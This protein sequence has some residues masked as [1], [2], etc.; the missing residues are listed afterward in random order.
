MYTQT[1][2]EILE[3]V[4]E[5]ISSLLILNYEADA[6]NLSLPDLTDSAAVVET[7]AQ[8][9]VN[10]GRSLLDSGDDELRTNMPP[11]CETG[12]FFGPFQ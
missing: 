4:A 8:N 11:T 10:I 5:A 6:Q 12:K 1:S 3:P 2:K 9:L 7:Q